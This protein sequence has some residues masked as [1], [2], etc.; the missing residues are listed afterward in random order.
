MRYD[1]QLY[2]HKAYYNTS[3]QPQ[4]QVVPTDQSNI[5]CCSKNNTAW[6][7]PPVQSMVPTP[8]H[9]FSLRSALYTSNFL[10]ISRWM[11][12]GIAFDGHKHKMPWLPEKNTLHLWVPVGITL[13]AKKSRFQTEIGEVP[14]L[15]DCPTPP[16]PSSSHWQHQLLLCSAP[17]ST[18]FSY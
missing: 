9:E 15:K 11:V 4:I 12:K 16:Q 8:E 6:K 17:Y 13:N 14:R 3:C 18:N 10:L 2:I 1:G 5:P 7:P